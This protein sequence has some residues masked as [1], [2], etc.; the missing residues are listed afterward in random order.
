VPEKQEKD[1]PDWKTDAYMADARERLKKL[2]SVNS[3]KD[4]VASP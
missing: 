1:Q 3:Q 2:R 4:R